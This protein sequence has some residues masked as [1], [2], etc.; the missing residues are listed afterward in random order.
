MEYSYTEILEHYPNIITLDQFYRI[1]HISKRKAKWLLENG[2]VPCQDS[3][4]KTH[5]FKIRTIDIVLYLQQLA[6]D[7]NH[8]PYPAGLFSSRYKTPRKVPC[9][10]ITLSNANDFKSYL[11]RIWRLSP[12]LLFNSD[13]HTI[14][15]YSLGTISHW[16]SSGQMKSIIVASKRVIAKEWLIDFMVDYSITHPSC[17]SVKHKEIIA[18]FTSSR[19]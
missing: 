14:T 16:V 4:K 12:D 6:Q 10:P 18:D 7:P 15:G 13:I 11:N 19:A 8:L 1:C 9:N 3:G 17:L 2:I 5:R